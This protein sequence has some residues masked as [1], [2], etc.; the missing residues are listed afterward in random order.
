MIAAIRRGSV[1]LVN[2]TVLTLPPNDGRQYHQQRHVVVMSGNLR[3][4]D[5]NWPTVLVVPTSTQG[6]LATA[7]C[8]KLDKGVGNLPKSCWARA[9]MPQP[10]LKEDLRDRAG[11]LPLPY[12]D[13]IVNGMLNYMGLLD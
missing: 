7:Y 2:D 4:S 1:F 12:V 6:K 13:L 11:D 5:P 9:T 10:I 8:V 3:N